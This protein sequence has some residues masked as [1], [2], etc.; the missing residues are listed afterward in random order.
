MNHT[1]IQPSEDYA[2][3]LKLLVSMG[4]DDMER[5]RKA[6]REANGLLHKSIEILSGDSERQQIRPKKANLP[7]YTFPKLSQEQ[8]QKVLQCAA[9]GFEDEGKI[10]HALTLSKW[11]V[12]AAIDRLVDGDG[13]LDSGYSSLEKG[14]SIT[15]LPQ[16]SS[17]L[18]KPSYSSPDWQTANTQITNA[19]SVLQS[20][21]NTPFALYSDPFGE[22]SYSDIL[23][24]RPSLNTMGSQQNQIPNQ[25]SSHNIVHH[26]SPFN[27]FVTQGSQ[28]NMQSGTN[29]DMFKNP[30]VDTISVFDRPPNSTS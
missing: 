4:F 12:E 19:D 23:Q 2:H 25:P 29:Y 11:E 10:R 14:T 9:M 22:S 17:S 20:S 21:A 27:P 13:I 7:V 16:R 24:S 30:H 15:P 18:L 5:N 3:T 1:E 8:A 28:S 26:H 6:V